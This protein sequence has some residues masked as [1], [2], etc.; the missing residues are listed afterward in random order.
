M[1]IFY[2]YIP[3]YRPAS[4][5]TLPR[6]DWIILERPKLHIAGFQQRLDLPMSQHNYGVVGFRQELTGLACEQYE[7]KPDGQQEVDELSQEPRP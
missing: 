2:R 3:L 5:F 4:N 1:T 6:R 7:L